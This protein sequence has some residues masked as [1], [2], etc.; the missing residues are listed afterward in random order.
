MFKNIISIPFHNKLINNQ[1]KFVVAK[2]RFFNNEINKKKTYII[3]KIGI[4]H[5]GSYKLA[6]KLIINAAL[7]GAGKNFK[8]LIL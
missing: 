8:C 7:A 4:N 5:E 1:I 3:A 6:K 2:C